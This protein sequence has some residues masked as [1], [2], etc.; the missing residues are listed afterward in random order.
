MH[1]NATRRFRF[2]LPPW[3]LPAMLFAAGVPLALCSFLGLALVIERFLSLRRGLVI[4]RGFLDGLKQSMR[5]L[6][7]DREA[8]LVYCSTH[9]SPIARIMAAGIKKGP[10][11]PEAGEKAIEDAGAIETLKLR[12]NMR[13]L[14]SLASISTLLGLI[15]TIQGMI[16][17]FQAAEVV[18]TG[19]FGPLAAGIYTALITTF[20]GLA[21]AIPITVFYFYFA[22]K[23]ERLVADMNDVATDFA[24]EYT[25][26]APHAWNAQQQALGSGR[27]AAG[28]Q[29][30][31]IPIPTAPP[32][33]FSPA[34]ATA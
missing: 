26:V 28:P 18:G 27:S 11:G 31:P 12:R 4:P 21:V 15:G 24:D 23:I 5:S 7:N 16:S 20:A 6:H 34:G 1:R 2:R 17:A 3:V 32:G 30:V 25:T 22:G 33:G 29:A 14:Y 9:D 13:F 19:K 8:G 10:R